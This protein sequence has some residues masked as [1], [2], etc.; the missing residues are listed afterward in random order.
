MPLALEPGQ[1]YPI[2]LDTDKDKPAES[3]PTFFARSQSMRGQQSIGTVLE[4]W[5]KDDDVSIA[6][7]F[8][9]TCKVLSTVVV[10]WKHMNGMEF[11][12]DALRDVLTYSEAREL[13]RKAMYNQHITQDEKKST[14]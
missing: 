4:L 13:L 2:V 10:G 12:P 1:Q 9:E 7:L 11:T 3:R 14:E 6:D 5:T 8:D